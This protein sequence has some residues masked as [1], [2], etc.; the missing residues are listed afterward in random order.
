MAQWLVNRGDSQFTVEG[1]SGLEEL[2][3]Q[4]DLDAG[5]LIQ[6]E[7]ADDWLYA[8]EIPELK[9]LV[10][11]TLEDDDDLEF[12]KSGNGGRIALYGLF[13]LLLIGGIGGMGYFFTQLPTGDEALVGEG[14]ALAYTELITTSSTPLLSE[15]EAGSS[16]VV[17]L[18][19]DAVVEL[20][21]KR[22]GFYKART[23]EGQTGWV[24]VDDIL[25]VYTMGDDRTKRRMDPLYNPDQYVK[26]SNASWH[27]IIDPKSDEKPIA[28]FSFLIENTSMYPM[29]D[30]RL[31]AV[32]K[33]SKGT[34][35]D[36]VEF[37]IE[38]EIPP[39]RS[40]MVGTLS[41]PE[42]EVE[43]AEEAG[44]EPPEPRLM[45]TQTFQDMVE[46]LPEDAQEERDA[47]YGRW[48]DGVEIEVED[49][50]VEATVRVVELRAV[51]KDEQE[52]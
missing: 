5:D 47:L 13:G 43:A 35:V 46:E 6:P 18:P 19:K 9:G 2:A 21:A 45:A 34:E 28:T 33:D 51:P 42:D 20:L 40:T 38:G 32:I 26:V 48:L 30:L 29:T 31:E 39:E 15:P 24:A 11:S 3:K 25:A 22:G 7:G 10:R 12:R 36:A 1:L 41:P 37:A 49:D 27:T 4:G 17:T 14:G 50:F 23:R 8:I 52:G 16:P 44:E